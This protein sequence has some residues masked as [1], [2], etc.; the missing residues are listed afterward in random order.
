M[1]RCI[2]KS[3]WHTH[4]CSSANLYE[5]GAR[6]CEGL[7]SECPSLG[8]RAACSLSPTLWYSED[9]YCAR[10]IRG[11]RGAYLA[12]SYIGMAQKPW[13]GSQSL[14][15]ELWANRE[16]TTCQESK[17]VM[18]PLT[19][20]RPLG[21]GH[22]SM[23]S[24]LLPAPTTTVN[25]LQVARPQRLALLASLWD[26]VDIVYQLH[27]RCSAWVLLGWNLYASSTLLLT[28]FQLVPTSRLDSS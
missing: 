9:H 7:S 5:Q 12:S 4:V 26:M 14:C 19:S 27:V 17:E 10:E 22:G 6:L 21:W 18:A 16:P 1:L 11:E 13:L 23:N 15:P 25:I 8:I 2:L 20:G 3:S 28:A 24:D